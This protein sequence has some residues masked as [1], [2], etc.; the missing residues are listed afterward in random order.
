[1]KELREV[2][3]KNIQELRTKKKITQFHLAQAL[4]YSDKAVSKWER[5]ESTPDI[6]VLKQIAD[7]FGVSV[8]YLLTE[9]HSAHVE[10]TQS[11]SAAVRHNRFIISALSVSLIWCIAVFAFVFL[12]LSPKAADF[13]SWLV[14]LYAA[15]VSMIVVLVFNSIW[16]KRR[17]NFLIISLMVWMTLISVYVSFVVMPPYHNLWPVF[18]LGIPAQLI[19]VLWSGLRTRT[20]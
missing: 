6:T 12:K 5:A 20:V 11:I 3:A 15:P 9:E 2:I 4:N 8:D 1:M 19:I 10:R 17:L 18:F 16:G 14:F 7:F 13:Q